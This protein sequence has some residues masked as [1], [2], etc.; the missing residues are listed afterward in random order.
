MFEFIQ[1]LANGIRE[2]FSFGN[3]PIPK[4]HDIS[5]RSDIE[6][7]S[8]DWEVIGNDFK[9]VMNDLDRAIVKYADENKK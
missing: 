4:R 7:L 1:I 9:V 6:V 2:I 5:V 8:E 3:I